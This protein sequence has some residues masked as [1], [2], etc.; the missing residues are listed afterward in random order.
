MVAKKISSSEKLLWPNALRA[1]SIFLVV[2]IHVCAFVLEPETEVSFPNQ[3]V[4]VFLDS[5]ARISVPIFLMISGAFL[6]EKPDKITTFFKKRANRIILP[7]FFW[8]TIQLFFNHY[9]RYEVFGDSD[10]KLILIRNFLSGFWFM[11]MIV[12]IYFVT[13]FIKPFFKNAKKT[14]YFYFF[15][16]WFI[17]ASLIPTI[18]NLLDL[19]KLYQLPI[20][21]NYLGYFIGGYFFTKEISGTDKIVSISKWLLLVNFLII[22]FGTLYLLSQNNFGFRLF[23]Y[24]SIPVVLM[25]FASFLILK[26]YFEMSKIS[27]KTQKI[28]HFLSDNSFGIF[29]S[30]MMILRTVE[31]VLEYSG[32]SI[33]DIPTVATIPIITIFGFTTSL[34]IV[35]NLRKI[36]YIKKLAG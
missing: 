18:F 8:G 29:L 11:P 2:L 13:P 25:S 31:R 9:F 1:I 19:T 27:N 24:L 21:L 17:F 14:E 16:F 35:S 3:A 10:F 7:W 23:E 20:W 33:T 28:I 22:S 15:S 36:S 12:G 30:H 4:A 26:N 32:V 6:L 34:I 5:I